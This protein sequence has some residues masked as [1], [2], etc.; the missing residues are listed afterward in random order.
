MWCSWVAQVI[1]ELLSWKPSD[2]YD[3][4]ICWFWSIQIFGAS[5]PSTTIFSEPPLNILFPP[6]CHIKWTFP[7]SWNFRLQELK[8]SVF[9]SNCDFSNQF[10]E[11][12]TNLW[13]KNIFRG[14]WVFIWTAY[15]MFWRLDWN[16]LS[17]KTGWG[18]YL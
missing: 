16:T 6:P 3:D 15:P 1:T 13:K 11:S 18:V 7:Y 4:V 14:Q 2:L 17:L 8:F 10:N 5:P 9:T 12:S